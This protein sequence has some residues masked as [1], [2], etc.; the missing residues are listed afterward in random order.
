MVGAG[1]IG[2]SWTQ[3]FV[4]AGIRTVLCDA[5][6][7]ALARA[8]VELEASLAASGADGARKLLTVEADLERAVA[9]ADWIQEA[10]PEDLEIKRAVFTAMDAAAPAESV[11]ASSASGFPMTMIADGL[12]GAHRC[13]VVHPTNPP[14]LLRLVEV[15]AGCDTVEPTVE[16]AVAFMRRLGQVPITCQKEIFGF[17]LNRLQ[18][19]L[20]REAMYLVR[21]GVVSVADVDRCVSEGL[22]PRWALLGPFGVEETNARSVRDCF[23]K[24]AEFF[25]TSFDEVCQ[26]YDGPSGADVDA[27]EAGVAELMGERTHDELVAYRNEMLQGIR[28]L[29]STASG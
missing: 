10:V 7:E 9:V 5:N 11:L 15:V 17:V 26:P 19:A 1:A 28:A 3:L 29:K 27:I 4:T 6:A 24:F 22:G 23:E 13:V 12:E 2:R 8:T 14:H 16:L 25:S 20:V 18:F 21:Q